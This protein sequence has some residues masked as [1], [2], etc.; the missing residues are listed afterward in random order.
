M[1][2]I[3]L[4]IKE[5]PDPNSDGFAQLSPEKLAEI[6]EA[7]EADSTPFAI[8]GCIYESEG[9]LWVVGSIHQD[10]RVEYHQ[11][12]DAG[13]SFVMGPDDFEKVFKKVEK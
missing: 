5:W 9:L 12:G 8:P 1:R 10:G 7:M 2:Q 4:V 3:A 6:T 11:K 13:R